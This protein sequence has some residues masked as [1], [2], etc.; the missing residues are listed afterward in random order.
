MIAK[1][2]KIDGEQPSDEDLKNRLILE[3]YQ[4]EDRGKREVM[5]EAIINIIKWGWVGKKVAK[6]GVLELEEGEEDL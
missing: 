6:T 3:G 2:V 4:R 1:K 5:D